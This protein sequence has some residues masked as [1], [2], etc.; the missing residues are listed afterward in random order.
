M[1]IPLT[2]VL[3]LASQLM[4]TGSW[5]QL[6]QQSQPGGHLQLLQQQQEQQLYGRLMQRV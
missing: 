5:Q 3:L 1:D 2:L 6:Q 4:S